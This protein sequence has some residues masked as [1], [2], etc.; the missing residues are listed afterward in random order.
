MI[1]APVFNLFFKPQRWANGTYGYLCDPEMRL[2]IVLMPIK[3]GERPSLIPKLPLYPN[4][5]AEGIIAY[6]IVSFKHRGLLLVREFYE[7][8]YQWRH[9]R[10]I[11][12]F[13]VIIPAESMREKF[14]ELHIMNEEKALKHCKM[15]ELLDGKEWNKLENFA[16]GYIAYLKKKNKSKEKK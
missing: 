6:T 12:E 3:E 13:K 11:K 7:L 14:L 10:F 8:Y 16:N 15:K 1:T 9:S 2:R 4:I 5:V